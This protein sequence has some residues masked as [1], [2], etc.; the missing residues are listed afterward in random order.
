MSKLPVTRHRGA[1]ARPDSD[2]FEV[3][4]PKDAARQGFGAFVSFHYSYT[5]VSAS[6]RKARVKAHR[7]SLEE[8]KLVS[9]SFEAE[10]G[11][12][13]YDH[14]AGQARQLVENQMRFLL[15]PLSWFLPRSGRRDR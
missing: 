13:G 12:D 14:I 10:L 8:G 5:E 4:E 1:V 2:P 9:E 6:G 11:R 7:A 15:R 3:I